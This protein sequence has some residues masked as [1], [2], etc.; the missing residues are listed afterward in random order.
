MCGCFDTPHSLG[1]HRH[2]STCTY[3]Y[4]IIHNTS[5]LQF[6]FVFLG[7]NVRFGCL[8]ITHMLLTSCTNQL[9]PLSVFN[10]HLNTGKITLLYAYTRVLQTS[11]PPSQINLQ[12]TETYIRAKFYERKCANCYICLA[13]FGRVERELSL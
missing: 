12:V 2:N 13:L 1:F 6:D 7:L 3:L 11:L 9:L 5:N 8:N 4:T 10:G